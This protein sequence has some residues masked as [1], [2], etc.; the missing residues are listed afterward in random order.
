[1][2]KKNE[3]LLAPVI[4]AGTSLAIGYVV[5]KA[6]QL[7]EDTLPRLRDALDGAVD[8]A[9]GVV[10]K[11]PDKARSAVSSGSDLAE[12]LTDRVRDATGP[13]GGEGALTPDELASRSEDR[14]KHRAKRRKADR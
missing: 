12:Q 7:M 9:G 13:N 5:K 3:L 8:S 1:M 11:V 2:S 6:P 4:A 10:E 14:A